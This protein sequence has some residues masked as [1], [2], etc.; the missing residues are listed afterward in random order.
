[1]YN[2]KIEEETVQGTN[3]LGLVVIAAVIGIALAQLG[4]EAK[5]LANLFHSL[6]ATMMKITTWVIWLSPI[7]ITFLVASKILEMEDVEQVMSQLGWYFA[8]VVIGLLIQGF[9]VLPLLYFALTRKSPITYTVNMTQALA[10]AFG[11]AS[12]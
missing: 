2:W 4:D 6:T 1:M 3:I 12:R 5:T 10:T 9:I 11:T 7:G 8:T